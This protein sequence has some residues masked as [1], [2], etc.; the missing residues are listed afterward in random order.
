VPEP[1]SPAYDPA[2]VQGTPGEPKVNTS[3]KT[4]SIMGS[5]N[6]N[7]GSNIQASK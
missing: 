4:N 2:A 7:V 3:L 6:S 1:G 5:T